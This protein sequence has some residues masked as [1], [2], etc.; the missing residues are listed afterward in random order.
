MRLTHIPVFTLAASLLL[1]NASGFA[2]EVVIEYFLSGNKTYRGVSNPITII[3]ENYSCKSVVVKS[4]HGRIEKTGDCHFNYFCTDNSNEDTLSIFVKKGNHLKKVS[5]RNFFVQSIPLPLATI[6]GFKNGDSISLKS[7][8]AQQGV[9]ANLNCCLIDAHYTV[10]HYHL[11]VIRKGVI[12]F[13]Q[14][15]DSNRFAGLQS[16]IDQLETGDQVIIGD[17]I[18]KGESGKDLSLLPVQYVL[19]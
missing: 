7:F 1:I 5:E 9:G 11:I 17:I 2:Q 12:V 8:K 18:A 14:Q 4:K 6:G 19:K 10:I 15:E 16:I 13:D 3:V